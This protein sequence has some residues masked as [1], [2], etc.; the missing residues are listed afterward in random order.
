MKLKFLAVAAALVVSG[1]AMAKTENLG[2]LSSPDKATF[3]NWF[4]SSGSFTDTYTFTLDNSSNAVGGLF[5]FDLSWGLH[6]DLTSVSLTGGSLSSALVDSSPLSFSFGNLGAG[7]YSLLVSGVVSGQPA[8]FFDIGGVWYSGKVETSAAQVAA[9][10]PEPE[11]IAMMAL[12]LGAVGW[13]SRR[14]QKAAK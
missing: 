2:N 9:P 1:T 6:L 4:G 3:G 10:V 13:V 11:T 8:G 12:G 5:D 14:R 7:T